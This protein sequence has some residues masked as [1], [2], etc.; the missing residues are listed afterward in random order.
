MR[1]FVIAASP[2]RT[3]GWPAN[4]GLARCWGD[5]ILVPFVDCQYKPSNVPGRHRISGLAT[6]LIRMARSTD[7]G[8]T[9]RVEEPIGQRIPSGEAYDFQGKLDFTDP[10]L[11]MVV[12]YD[13]A[14]EGAS[15]L[16]YSFDRGRIWHGPAK[17]PG[18]GLSGLCGRTD[19]VPLDADRCLFLLTS[20]SAHKSRREGRVVA[21]V[22][23]DGGRAW[24]EPKQ[25]GTDPQAIPDFSIMSS[26]VML[27]DK[28]F[29]SALRVFRGHYL[30][31]ERT[32]SIEFWHSA[33]GVEWSER[34]HVIMRGERFSSPASLLAMPDGRLAV[35]YCE[36]ANLRV[37]ARISDD[38]GNEW[39][40]LVVIRD[41][42]KCWD[43]GYVRS[44]AMADGAVLTAYYWMDDLQDEPYIAGTIWRP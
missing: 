34:S 8:E 28:S 31:E 5:E 7:A 21:V 43:F 42:A 20:P 14:H 25:V 13:S 32:G 35:T 2:G 36:R 22:A 18:L 24:S 23:S 16:H 41:G 9:W 40:D 39:G 1:S 12:G 10:D 38:N 17:I 37:V 3:L 11:C 27:R 6:Q 19:Y 44:V 15:A 29:L 30:K 33:D 26:T 4:N